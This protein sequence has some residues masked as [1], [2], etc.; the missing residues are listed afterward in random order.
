MNMVKNPPSQGPEQGWIG[1]SPQP[2]APGESL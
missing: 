2:V 1:L